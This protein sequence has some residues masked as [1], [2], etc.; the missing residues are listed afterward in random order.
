MNL[1]PLTDKSI[2]TRDVLLSELNRITEKGYAFEN[3]E[4][5]LDVR[6]I[7]VPIRDFSRNVIGAV[8]IVAPSHRLTEERLE[9]GD[10]LSLVKEAGKAISSKMGFIVPDGNK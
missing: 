6:S 10:L 5:D 9:K 8:G 4:A 1:T 7:A 3:E 2:Q